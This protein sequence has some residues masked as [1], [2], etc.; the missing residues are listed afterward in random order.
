MR[1]I[2]LAVLSVATLA[3]QVGVFPPIPPNQF[4]SK[5]NADNDLTSRPN[6]AVEIY[7]N[8]HPEADSS[9]LVLSKKATSTELSA[10]IDFINWYSPFNAWYNLGRISAKDTA[11]FGG[12]L[13]FYTKAAANGASAAP[14]E[15]LRIDNLGNV[16]I[17]T[18]ANAAVQLEVAGVMRTQA[19][20]FANLPNC[21]AGIEGSTKAVTNS[22]TATWGATITGGGANHVLAYCNG[23]NWTVAAK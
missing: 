20:V 6:G 16:S 9:V 13:I 8:S 7:D 4:G 14:A 11:G 22:T 18:G 19:E 23:T 21:G 10:N 3:A 12:L 1:T 15:R 5:A 17:G 2:L